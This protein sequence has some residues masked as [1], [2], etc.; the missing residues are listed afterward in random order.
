M[1]VR[2]CKIAN[3]SAS[4]RSIPSR[5][6]WNSHGDGTE[7]TNGCNCAPGPLGLL[8]QKR[9]IYSKVPEI[10]DR[11]TGYGSRLYPYFHVVESEQSPEV[12]VE[13]RKMIMLGSNNY[14]G[15]P[16]IRR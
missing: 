12:I 6:G 16:T 7:K 3:D 8:R 9:R 4:G 5:K 14:L 13:G 2:C 10:H 11:K 15:L 1:A